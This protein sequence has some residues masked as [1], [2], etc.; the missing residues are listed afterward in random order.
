MATPGK[1]PY[2]FGIK[3]RLHLDFAALK[4]LPAGGIQGLLRV[5]A[6]VDHVCNNLNV[7]LGLHIAAHN[8]EGAKGLAIFC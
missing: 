7:A 6:E 3:A 8:P 5:K 1:G 4:P 2:N